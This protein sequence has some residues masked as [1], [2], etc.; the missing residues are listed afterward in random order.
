MGVPNL[1]RWDIENE[2]FW[3]L[4]RARY[5]EAQPVDLDPSL[6]CGFAVWLY[7]SIITTQML[8]L[9]FPFTKEQ[10]FTLPASPA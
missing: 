6:L 3:E 10:L 4:D 1:S 7:W 8:E 2:E 9:Q 5:R